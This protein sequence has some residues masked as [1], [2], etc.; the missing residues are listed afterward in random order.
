MKTRILVF[1][2]AVFLHTV[3]YECEGMSY[4]SGK[5]KGQVPPPPKFLHCHDTHASQTSQNEYKSIQ[6]QISRE[7]Y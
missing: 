4:F 3:I 2:F 1:L 7:Y 5:S 6:N